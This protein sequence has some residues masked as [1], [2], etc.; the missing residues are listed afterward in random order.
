MLSEERT[1]VW[2]T[3]PVALLPAE[4]RPAPGCWSLALG[5]SKWWQVVN[6]SL[7]PH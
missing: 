7:V 6:Q 2:A 5:P 3:F 4:L 1:A